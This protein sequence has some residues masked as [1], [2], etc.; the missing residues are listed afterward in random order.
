[1]F[2][3][4]FKR[5][6][7]TSPIIRKSSTAFTKVEVTYPGK[8]RLQFY[9]PVNSTVEQFVERIRAQTTD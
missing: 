5:L 4:N 8:R 3:R 9:V 1:M 7:G 6:F 2:G